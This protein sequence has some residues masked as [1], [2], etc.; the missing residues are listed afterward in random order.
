[1][2]PRLFHV[3]AHFARKSQ[4][5]FEFWPA[6]RAMIMCSSTSSAATSAKKRRRRGLA[7]GIL[8]QDLSECPGVWKAKEVDAVGGGGEVPLVESD[9][10]IFY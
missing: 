4:Q 6:E 7:M 9:L 1:M 2:G 10:L 3:E 5:L 8:A